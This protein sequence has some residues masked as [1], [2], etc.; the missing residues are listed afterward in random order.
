MVTSVVTE[1]RRVSRRAG[2]LHRVL[3]IG[4]VLCPV[5][6]SATTALAQATGQQPQPAPPIAGSPQ[7]QMTQGS[8]PSPQSESHTAGGEANLKLPD[9]SSVEFRGVNGRRLLEFG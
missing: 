3:V 6:L 7:H 4:L 5:V 9:M 8:G 2:N 1:L